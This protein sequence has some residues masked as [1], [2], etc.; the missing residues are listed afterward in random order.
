M[1]P[2]LGFSHVS[3]PSILCVP[4]D[5]TGM[6]RGGDRDV[7]SRAGADLQVDADDS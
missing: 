3:K 6:E 1:L 4:W 2:N 5:E 7:W